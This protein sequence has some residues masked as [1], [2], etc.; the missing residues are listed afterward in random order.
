MKPITRLSLPLVALLLATGIAGCGSARTSRPLVTD[1][2]IAAAQPIAQV[3][4]QQPAASTQAV[5]P[6]AVLGDVEIHS[7]EMGFKPAA[8]E[9]DKAGRYTVKL[10][11]DGVLPHDL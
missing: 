6:A 4:A 11:N 1:T 8:L 9:V 5:A 2:Q 7:F 3:A 10:V